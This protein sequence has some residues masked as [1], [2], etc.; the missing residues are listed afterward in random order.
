MTE[1]ASLEVPIVL[2]ISSDLLGQGR[3]VNKQELGEV[4]AGSF[5]GAA[6]LSFFQDVLRLNGFLSLLML[7][8]GG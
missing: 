4:G 2:F 8:Q 7:E 6:V 1:A 3:P 5:G